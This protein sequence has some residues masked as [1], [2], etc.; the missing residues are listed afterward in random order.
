MDI[1]SGHVLRNLVSLA[2]LLAALGQC[3]TALAGT[4]VTAKDVLALPMADR[5]SVVI[6]GVQERARELD[7]VRATIH[8]E[9]FN[10]QIVDGDVGEVTERLDRSDQTIRRIGDSYRFNR[11][12]RQGG[13]DEVLYESNSGYNAGTGITRMWGSHSQ[14]PYPNARV[15]YTKDPVVRENWYGYFLGGNIDDV[16]PSFLR[17]LIDNGKILEVTAASGDPTKLV[18]TVSKTHKD[19]AQDTRSYW[20]SPQDGYFIS[21]VQRR[22]ERKGD[23]GSLAF[24]Y[25][26]WTVL[27]TQSIDGV[28]LPSKIRVIARSQFLPADVGTVYEIEATDLSLGDVT[29]SDL[30]V[31]FPNG[32]EVND[33]IE[34]KIYFVGRES[35]SRTYTEGETIP[36]DEIRPEARR[37]SWLLVGNIALVGVVI[38]AL[39]AR[40]YFRERRVAG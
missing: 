27:E 10:A 35:E 22:W 15:T 28:V 26:D 20:L 40:Q 37:Y 8:V 6:D 36:A 13:S 17:Y 4:Q 38:L 14:L 12:Y 5:R 16:R 18:V 39:L 11:T 23:D 25:R 19:N 2:A 9:R 3:C 33:M 7:N 34:Q 21:K 31:D 30:A 1:L 24:D 29:E 32:T